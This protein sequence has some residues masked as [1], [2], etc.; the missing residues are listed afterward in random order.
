VTRFLKLKGLK[1]TALITDGRF[2]DCTNGPSSAMSAPRPASTGAI[3]RVHDGDRIG[4]GIPNMSQVWSF[5]K[6]KKPRNSTSYG[7]FSLVDVGHDVLTVRSF[8][9]HPSSI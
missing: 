7:A 4:I 9:V 3:A 6:E 2:S 5:R 8:E 1:K